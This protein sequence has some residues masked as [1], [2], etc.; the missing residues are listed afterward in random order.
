MFVSFPTVNF[1]DQKGE[2]GS[3]TP[4]VEK[5]STWTVLFEAHASAEM[6]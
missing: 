3:Y 2:K 5:D 1:K 4:R 6:R